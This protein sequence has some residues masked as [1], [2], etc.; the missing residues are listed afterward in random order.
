MTELLAILAAAAVVYVLVL[1]GYAVGAKGH[2]E[3][4]EAAYRR[5]QNMQRAIDRRKLR[6]LRVALETETDGLTAEQ[7]LLLYDV[8][9]ALRLSERETQHVVGPAVLLV[10]DAPVDLGVFEEDADGQG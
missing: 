7:A 10:I 9:Q 8:C 6:D 3:T 5:G 2:R 1:S 4:G